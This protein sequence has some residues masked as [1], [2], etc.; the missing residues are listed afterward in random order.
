MCTW[1]PLRLTT[2]ICT[3]GCRA[4][5]RMVKDLATPVVGTECSV[6]IFGMKSAQETGQ[7]IQGNVR[8]GC[9][10]MRWLSVMLHAR[11]CMS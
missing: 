4:E 5:L 7:A 2:G 11:N 3:K 9:V 6:C 1:L 10:G 8:L